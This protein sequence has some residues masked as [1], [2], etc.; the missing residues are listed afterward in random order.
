M[1]LA[2]TLKSS[3]ERLVAI[4]DAQ[5]AAWEAAGMPTTF[6]VDGESYDWNAWLTARLEELDKLTEQIQK[7]GGSFIVRSRGRP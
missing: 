2:D 6:S 5:L 3:R 4:I 7:V 1:A